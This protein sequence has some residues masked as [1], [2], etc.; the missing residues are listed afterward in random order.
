LPAPRELVND[1]L[2]KPAPIIHTNVKKLFHHELEHLFELEKQ[3]E[4]PRDW[5]QDA[6]KKASVAAR[7]AR[8]SQQPSWITLTDAEERTL[9]TYDI[10]FQRLRNAC[11]DKM[12]SDRPMTDEE[13]NDINWT[14]S[15]L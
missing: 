11:V 6:I 10:Q 13:L 9:V 3:R 7:H 15:A 12:R 5:V 1:L 14:T 4:E 2:D 8:P